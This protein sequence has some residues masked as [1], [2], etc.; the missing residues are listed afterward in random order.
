MFSRYPVNRAPTVSLAD[1]LWVTLLAAMAVGSI[2][3]VYAASF[4]GDG[5]TM[6]SILQAIASGLL[7]PA[8]F[9]GGA[10][11]ALLGGSLHYAILWVAS[12]LFLLAARAF[13]IF[14]RRPLFAGLGFGAG[15]YVFM[16]FIVVPL[17]AAPFGIPADPGSVLKLLALHMI[18]IGLPIAGIV[19]LALGVRPGRQGAAAN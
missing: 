12:A 8:A 5:V 17:S 1:G 14:C 7:G 10:A 4:A 3:L 9:Q 2:D 6:T 11:T 19:A 15:L 16:S 13:P 18:G